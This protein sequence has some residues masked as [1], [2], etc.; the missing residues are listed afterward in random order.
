MECDQWPLTLKIGQ[1]HLN[2]MKIR[3]FHNSFTTWN[4]YKVLYALEFTYKQC[5]MWFFTFYGLNPHFVKNP[6]SEIFLKTAYT[7]SMKNDI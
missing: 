6:C 1:S 3:V 5:D 4:I 2:S 7:T